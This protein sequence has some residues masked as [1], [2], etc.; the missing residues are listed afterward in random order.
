MAVYTSISTQQATELA[1][2]HGLG[3]L[4]GIVPIAAGSVNSNYFIDTESG[5]RFLRIYEEQEV[6]GVA[7]EWRLLD[8]LQANGL[9]VPRRVQ[10]PAPG[11]QR[12][13]GK[14]TAV[15]ELIGGQQVEPAQASVAAA[16]AV[17]RALAQVHLGLADFPVRHAGRFGLTEL[18][19]RLQTVAAARRPELAPVVERLAGVLAEL[20]T[21]WPTHLP[22]GIVHGDLFPDNVYWEG[23]RIVALIDW[24]SA[25]DGL[26]AHDLMITVLAWCYSEG[27]EWAKASAMVRAYDELRPLQPDEIAALH[28]LAQAAAARFTITRLTDSYLRDSLGDRVYLD[29]RQYLRRL[30]ALQAM[31]SKDLTAMLGLGLPISEV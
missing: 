23:Q 17:G 16:A 2:A 31:E 8:H 5:R 18:Q 26:W 9:P 15:F 22:R 11:E 24:E 25:S 12:I 7:F 13:A 4:K 28:L 10:G 20:Q 14:P 3:E 27:F 29:Y 30:D 1:A 21:A 19:Q 6:D